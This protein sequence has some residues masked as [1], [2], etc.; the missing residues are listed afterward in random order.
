MFLKIIMQKAVSTEDVKNFVNIQSFYECLNVLLKSFGV[1]TLNETQIKA[2]TYL[3]VDG[4][5]FLVSLGYYFHVVVKPNSN[6]HEF[7]EGN[8]DYTGIVIHPTAM[9]YNNK[10]ICFTVK[11]GNVIYS[12]CSACL[13]KRFDIKT[14]L[15]LIALY[16]Y[17]K[18]GLCLNYFYIVPH[19]TKSFFNLMNKLD[20]L[21][22]SFNDLELLCYLS[23]YSVSSGRIHD[24]EVVLENYNAMIYRTDKTI[25]YEI[26]RIDTVGMILIFDKH[27]QET[28][29]VVNRERL[30][31]KDDSMYTNPDIIVIRLV[32][33][34]KDNYIEFMDEKKINNI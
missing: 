25:E 17:N 5:R 20:C 2:C 10:P 21:P 23:V 11:D 3:G 30:E 24:L 8:N 22:I 19:V 9:K 6:V 14:D 33:N 4:L 15:V 34:S 32:S 18:L 12:K 28:I 26:S 31:Q 27:L 16:G 29:T 13:E 1:S 7:L